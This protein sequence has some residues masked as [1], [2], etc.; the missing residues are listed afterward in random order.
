M[1]Y[2]IIFPLLLAGCVLAG[3]VDGKPFD[4]SDTGGYETCC[5]FSCDDGTSGTV[6]F[7]IDASDCSSYADDQCSLAGAGV[8][9]AD[10]SDG[11]C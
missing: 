1:R 4:S 8:S 9:S 2:T 11:G 3:C 5:A 10:F 7:T 6:T